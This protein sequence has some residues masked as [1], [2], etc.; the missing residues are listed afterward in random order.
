MSNRDVALENLFGSI[1]LRFQLETLITS[2][3]GHGACLVSD[4]AK[5]RNALAY[6]TG[7]LHLTM[8]NVQR[9]LSHKNVRLKPQHLSHQKQ[10][11]YSA[12]TK[13]KPTQNLFRCVD[14]PFLIFITISKG[15]M[16]LQTNKHK[17]NFIFSHS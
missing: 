13:K 15:K 3:R 10:R 9:K 5:I 12:H 2:R 14:D 6:S 11:H 1:M 4:K 17:Q 8:E 16:S 7:L